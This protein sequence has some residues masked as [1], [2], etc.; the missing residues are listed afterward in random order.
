VAANSPG[1]WVF[2]AG[3]AALFKQAQ[4]LRRKGVRRAGGLFLDAVGCRICRARLNHRKAERNPIQAEDDEKEDQ[5][6]RKY[7][8]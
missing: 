4:H 7:Q 6:D 8:T 3:E 2:G 1:V 5:G